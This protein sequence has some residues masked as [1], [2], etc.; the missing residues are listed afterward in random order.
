MVNHYVYDYET[1]S[2]CFVA[3][4]EHYK[5]K[6]R[7]IFVVHKLRNDFKEFI[8]FLKLASKE[9]QRHVSF[10]GLSFDSQISEFIIRNEKKLIKLSPDEI[11][12]EIYQKAQDII[13]KQDTELFAEYPEHKLSI[14]QLDV[15]KLNHWDNPNKRSSLK[16]IQYSLDWH[17]LL[18]MPISHTKTIR[19]QEELDI[20]IDYCINDVQSTKAIMQHSAE[21]IN[22]RKTLTNDYKINLYSA[23]EPKISKELFLDFLSKKTGE[24]KYDLKQARTIRENIKVKDIIL[25]SIAFD[26]IEFQQLLRNFKKLSIDPNN[27]KGAFKYKV[28]YKGIE[29]AYGLGG[30]HGATKAGIY[31]SDEDN[32]IMTSD[33][34][35]YYPNLAIRNRW[36]PAHLDKDN[37]VELYEWFFDERKKIPKK[38]PRNYT[39]KIILNSTFGLSIDKNSFLYD[40]QFGMQITINGQLL[41]TKLCEM[42]SQRIP[43]AIP[44]MLNTD[45]LETLI[46]RKYQD[47]YYEICKEWQEATKLELEH[48]T[49]QKV[50]LPDVNTYIA[51]GNPKKMNQED[52][53]SLKK[54]YPHY[55]YEEKDNEYYCTK[56]KCKGRFNF[57]DLALHKNKSYLAISKAVYNYFVFDIPIEKSFEE[58]KNIFDYCAGTKIKTKDSWYFYKLYVEN[59]EVKTEKLQNVLRY[60]ISNKGCKI[61]KKNISDN[62][63]IQEQA[64]PWMQTIMN[65]Y[66]PKKWEDYDINMNFYI[67]SANDEISNV[68]SYSDFFS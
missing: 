57:E 43:G 47:L 68:L 39:Y 29:I 23:S 37:F 26:C 28:R 42:L 60:Y 31:K 17:N 61:I 25:P 11:T 22:L 40:P 38:D 33:V 63:E 18:E 64:G 13:T 8:E 48:D 35:S 30:L 67:K 52:W 6:D 15:F 59:Q 2:N 1:L 4:Y 41:L 44:L 16:W 21:Q 9:G 36:S 7:H 65:K 66:I 55:I 62:R 27:I 51:I 54:D 56:T 34:I 45:G 49:Y 20:I 5:T 12:A 14:K 3:V 58:N 53:L 46:P 19:T 10:N 32:I 50:I 24:N